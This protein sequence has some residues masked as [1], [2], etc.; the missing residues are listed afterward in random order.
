MPT[1][2]DFLGKFSSLRLNSFENLE[3]SPTGSILG[4]RIN[5]I[6]MNC[7]EIT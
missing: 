2:T 4:A 3:I 6:G 7:L 1:P 5:R